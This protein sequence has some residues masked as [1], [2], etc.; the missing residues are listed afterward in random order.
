[1]SNH[2]VNLTG[3]NR[4]E[5]ASYTRCSNFLGIERTF[6]NGTGAVPDVIR[7]LRPVKMQLVRNSSGGVLYPGQIV[8]YKTLLSGKEV[9]N[10]AAATSG[11]HDGV[12]D[13]YITGTVADGDCFWMV[14]D[15]PT[16]FLPDANAVTEF[17]TL[18]VSPNV[19]GAV[20]TQTA[21][22]ADATAAMLQVNGAL[23]RCEVASSAGSGTL[24]TTTGF[25]GFYRSKK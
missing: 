6:H 11:R 23:G 8:T 12:V 5:T 25:Y 24:S 16:K 7:D 18:V 19:A 1:M 14:V 4:G 2:D 10:P 21:A 15:G 20:K 22:P 17:D 3:V 13:H 9:T